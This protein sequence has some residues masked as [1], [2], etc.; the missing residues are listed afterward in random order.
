MCSS[1]SKGDENFITTSDWQQCPCGFAL[2]GR[3][4]DDHCVRSH[5]VRILRHLGRVRAGLLSA[6]W[7]VSPPRDAVAR[8]DEKFA[9]TKA[10]VR[11][12][13]AMAQRD[14]LSS[15]LCKELGIERV[16]FTHAGPKV[17]L[18]T[19]GKHVL[20]LYVVDLPRFRSGLFESIICY[21]VYL[22]VI[23]A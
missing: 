23:K 1:I 3:R 6:P 7:R 17:S 8:A 4:I 16:T 13:V 15:D 21:Q 11:R 19:M 20:G 2:K 14:T 10:Q 12:A 18:E 5:G 22:Y 9:L